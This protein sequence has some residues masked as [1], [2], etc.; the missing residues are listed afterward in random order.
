MGKEKTNRTLSTLCKNTL[1]KSIRYII[2]L[3]HSRIIIIIIIIM[4]KSCAGMLEEMLKCAEQSKCYLS[5][6]RSRSRRENSFNSEEG[7]GND[8]DDDD[9][10]LEFCV[11]ALMRTTTTDD[12]DDDDEK[13]KNNKN[14]ITELGLDECVVKKQV[15]LKCK[16]GQMD[17]RTRM[18]GNKGY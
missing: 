18:R 11:N 12:D 4:S 6:S 1:P 14:Q 15:Y 8:D 17:M 16:R 5:R 10:A 7:G 9:D 13:K 2:D 3:T